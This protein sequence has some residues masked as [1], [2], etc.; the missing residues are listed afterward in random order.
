MSFRDRLEPVLVA[1]DHVGAWELLDSL[2]G[3]DLTQARAWFAA[4][5]R[6]LDNI[7]EHLTFAGRDADAQRATMYDAYWILAS[8]AV[9]LCGPVSAA[10]RVPWTWLRDWDLEQDPSFFV[11]RLW[12][13]DRAWAAAFV[14]EAANLSMG[15]SERRDAGWMVA[16]MVRLTVLHHDLPCPVGE[17]FLESWWAG[18]SGLEDADWRTHEAPHLD[19]WLAHEPLMPEL[20]L[21][22][23]AAGLCVESWLTPHIVTA[24]GSRVVGRDVVVATI[25]EALSRPPRPAAQLVFAG[26][27][28]GVDLQADEIPGGLTYLLGVMATCKGTV[29]KVLLPRALAL[30]A[31]PDELGDLVQ[32]VAAR[33]EKNHKVALLKALTTELPRRLG[34]EPVRAAMLVLSEDDDAAFADRVRR[35]LDEAGASAIALA[36]PVPGAPGGLWEMEPAPSDADLRPPY[37]G[38]PPTWQRV[39]GR[40]R[41]ETSQREIAW[42]VQTTLESL[43]HDPHAWQAAAQ[44]A[45]AAVLANGSL[46]LTRVAAVFGD[47]FVTGGLRHT[48]PVALWLAGECTGQAR[49][50]AGL[51]DLLRLLAQF[52][53]EIPGPQRPQLPASLVALAGRD[54]RS[55]AQMEARRLG[56]LLSGAADAETWVAQVRLSSSADVAARPQARGLWRALLPREP[57]P[58]EVRTGEACQAGTDLASLRALVEKTFAVRTARSYAAEGV[59][60]AVVAGIGAHGTAEVRRA[61]DGLRFDHQPVPEIR[62]IQLWATGNLDAAAYWR[63]VERSVGSDQVLTRIRDEPGLS[64]HEH[65]LLF[66]RLPSLTAQ[67]GPG[68]DVAAVAGLPDLPRW[69][70]ECRAVGRPDPGGRPLV[71][72]SWFGHLLPATQFLHTLECLLVADRTPVVLASPEWRDGT[73]SY[74]T[75]IRRLRSA[76]SRGGAVGHLDLVRALHRMRPVEPADSSRLDALEPVSTHP[77]LTSSAGDEAHDAVE[78]V[79]TWVQSGGLP[80]LDAVAVDG[81]WT[82]DAAS[83][84]AYATCR[85]VPTALATAGFFLGWDDERAALEPLRP[86]RTC[87]EAYAEAPEAGQIQGLPEALSGEVGEPLHDRYL[88]Q[89]THLHRGADLVRPLRALELPLAHAR[90]RTDLIVRAALG[91]HRANTLRIG[92]LASSVEVLCERGSLSALWEPMLEVAAALAEQPTRPSDLHALL[93]VLNRYVVEVPAPRHVPAGLRTLAA[94]KGSTKARTEACALVAALEDPGTEEEQ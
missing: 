79:R 57:D 77:P 23:L 9:V 8:A 55:K 84:V 15:A 78:L 32:L 89:L 67:L 93:R 46:R 2:S 88:A 56:A 19:S 28:D 66:E 68:F 61:L 50:M 49:P 90:L 86:D 12:E 27:L 22:R 17:V 5:K 44:P 35:A 48:Y 64:R 85:A 91:R 83:P 94:S 65:H 25:L 21:H 81:L 74:E 33:T 71:M 92:H 53:P 43:R 1:G 30:V 38:A 72:P 69:L 29:G 62:A 7:A 11:H 40:N 34:P 51:S 75:L 70:D 36:E 24:V 45:L 42:S 59:V 63:L 76:G 54:G 14:D 6:W 82:S 13:V 3:D 20:L 4:D 31:T 47:W 60:V 52:A 26:V 80:P 73:L 10:R 58:A 16:R 87:R 41:T 39:F 37:A 18:T